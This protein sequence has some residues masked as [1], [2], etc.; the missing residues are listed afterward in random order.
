MLHL[1]VS[2]HQ[3]TTSSAKDVDPAGET[4]DLVMDMAS[5][6]LAGGAPSSEAY[7]VGS[8]MAARIRETRKSFSRGNRHS[9]SRD[10]MSQEEGD[11]SHS[12]KPPSSNRFDDSGHSGHSKSRGGGGGGGGGGGSVMSSSRGQLFQSAR[13]GS[14]KRDS[15]PTGSNQPSRENSARLTASRRGSKTDSGQ[16][17]VPPLRVSTKRGGDSPLMGGSKE[18]YVIPISNPNTISN[19]HSNSNLIAI[20][21]ITNL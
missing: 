13:D 15:S 7:T 3:A 5:S 16:I 12:N 11:S 4:A 14:A 9:S 21:L 2:N 6:S 18:G 1:A 19:P 17:G 10:S 8:A 20:N